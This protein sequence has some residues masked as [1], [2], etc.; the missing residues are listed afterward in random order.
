[1]KAFVS[2][3]VEQ[4]Y[5]GPVTVGAT[6]P[7]TFQCDFDTGS[8]DF[9]VPGPKCGKAQGCPSSTKYDQ[10]GTD[11]HNTTTVTYGS[12]QISGENYFDSVTVAGL[13][14]KHQNVISLTQAQGFSTGGFSSLMGMAFST[15]AQSKQPTYFEN[16][17]SQKVVTTPEFGFFLGRAADGN[18]QD[19]ELTLGGQ[20]SSKYTGTVY[21]IPVTQVGYW[22]VALDKVIA[23]GKSAALTAGQAAIDTGTTIVLAPNAATASIYS[24]IPGSFPTTL[25]G[26]SVTIW[27]YPCSSTPQV[28]IVFNGHSFAID[29]R[30]F[31]FGTLTSAFADFINKD[32][33][34]QKLLGGKYCLGAIAGADLDPTENLY[35]VVS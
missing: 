35:V 12:G 32:S 21:K 11:E 7:Q 17:I 4:D 15:I 29:P 6:K 28:S 23:N 27:A 33:L 1:L 24:N 10:G 30:D 26:T 9:F 31:N 25:G 13:T 20:D 8:A 19:S 18:A 5:Y 22:Q 16:L 14:A 2:G 34:V 3:G